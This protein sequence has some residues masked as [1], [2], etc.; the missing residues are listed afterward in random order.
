MRRGIKSPI[1]RSYRLTIL[2]ENANEPTAIRGNHVAVH[3]NWRSSRGW[4]ETYFSQWEVVKLYR[5]HIL[6]PEAAL[7]AVTK[8]NH[9]V[10]VHLQGRPS[11]EPKPEVHPARTCDQNR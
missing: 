6:P 3:S 9:A 5:R 2:V 11:R 7:T 4:D 8:V 10:G 1:M